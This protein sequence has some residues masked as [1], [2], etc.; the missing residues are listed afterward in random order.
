MDF[1][2]FLYE[3]EDLFVKRLLSTIN[4]GAVVTE[5]F[6][7]RAVVLFCMEFQINNEFADIAPESWLKSFLPKNPYLYVALYPERKPQAQEPFDWMIESD[8]QLMKKYIEPIECAVPL[9][10]STEII[11]FDTNGFLIIRNRKENE[12]QSDD[13]KMEYWWWRNQRG[14]IVGNSV[15][16]YSRMTAEA[17]ASARL[18]STQY[19]MMDKSDLEPKPKRTKKNHGCSIV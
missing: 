12:Q 5:L 6:I 13:E 15:G 14:F 8:E 18:A 1:N 16:Y 19:D 10:V 3:E 7:R 9:D 17:F 2:F 4:S 11:D